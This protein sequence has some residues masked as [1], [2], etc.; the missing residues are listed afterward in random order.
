M[1]P[2]EGSTALQPRPR[3]LRY[4]FSR[5][6]PLRNLALAAVIA[7]ACTAIV[8]V[9]A[10]YAG[11]RLH[12]AST[13]LPASQMATGKPAPGPA[14][15]AYQLISP[16]P[17]IL[18]QLPPDTAPVV[19]KA[20]RNLTGAARDKYI[21]QTQEEACG[22]PGP[23]ARYSTTGVRAFQE[24]AQGN[25]IEA[26][27]SVLVERGN[28]WEHT[29]A[30]SADGKHRYHTYSFTYRCG[31]HELVTPDPYRDQ[32]YADP[33]AVAKDYAAKLCP[34]C[35]SLRDYKDAKDHS[36]GADKQGAAKRVGHG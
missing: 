36:A 17:E 18:A 30:F 4:E 21:S 3:H 19:Y 32:M 22:Q 25:L 20:P 2:D 29:V 11:P 9:V 26:C 5:L 7:L 28:G 14:M 15:D 10:Y 1:P 24:D 13:P 12:V 34:S 27:P 33:T 8:F 6:A 35:Q 16:T 23:W 31:H